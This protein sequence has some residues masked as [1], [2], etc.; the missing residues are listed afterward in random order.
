VERESLEF[1]RWFYR[2]DEEA[3]SIE[4]RWHPDLV[5]NQSPDMPGTAGTFPGYEGLR[6]VNRELHESWEE[7]AWVPAEVHELGDE[8][9][10]ILLRVSGRGR[11]S[12]IEL[13][14]EIGHIVTFRGEKAERLDAY[15]GW[16]AA[17]E[18]A[19]IRG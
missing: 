9:Y 8:R 19:G 12:G 14:G 13:E 1:W 18:A 2:S 16:D 17:R 11:G 4:E 6:A 3:P 15:L 7:I 10:L 5:L